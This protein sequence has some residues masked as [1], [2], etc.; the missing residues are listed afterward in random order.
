MSSAVYYFPE[1]EQKNGVGT[2]EKTA[3]MPVE[4]APAVKEA[5]QWTAAQNI[6]SKI[7]CSH[8]ICYFPDVDENVDVN[9]DPWLTD[10]E[11]AETLRDAIQS[12]RHNVG[13]ELIL[14]DAYLEAIA[15]LESL[16]ANHAQLAT[17]VETIITETIA[18][19]V[20]EIRSNP[21]TIRLDHPKS[22]WFPLIN[23]SKP[24]SS[25][26]PKNPASVAVYQKP[27]YEKERQQKLKR[28]GQLLKKTREEQ[29][30]SRNQ[31]NHM[32]HILTHHIEAIEEGKFD[33]LP[34]DLYVR[35][36]VRHL[37]NALKLDGD[38]LAKALPIQEWQ[39]TQAQLIPIDTGFTNYSWATEASRYIGYGTLIAGAV[40]GLSWSMQQS[41]TESITLSEPASAMNQQKNEARQDVKVARSAIKLAPPEIMIAPN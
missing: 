39:K 27:S 4:E 13:R 30:V 26:L 21:Q 6:T 34:E 16:S 11:N 19:T 29:A 15:G 33:Q 17:W 32:T 41:H 20:R 2:L 36:F 24:F 25:A 12:V 8:S 31:L 37:G 5:S 10:S 3:P 1:V 28:I 40:S 7:N 18:A 22:S 9:A 23:S 35:G 14:N 38:T